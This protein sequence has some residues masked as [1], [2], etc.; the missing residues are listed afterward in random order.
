MIESEASAMQRPHL[1]FGLRALC[2][3]AEDK[4]GVS[5]LSSVACFSTLWIAAANLDLL[6]KTTSRLD[7]LILKPASPV[8]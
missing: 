6:R 8:V 5:I 7:M 3:F 2:I 1:V 4:A